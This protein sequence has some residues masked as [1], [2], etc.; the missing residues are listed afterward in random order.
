MGKT[1][2]EKSAEFRRQESQ[3]WPFFCLLAVDQLGKSFH[4]LG[5]LKLE[6]TV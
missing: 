5:L 1:G 4:C 2:G 6:V 3:L